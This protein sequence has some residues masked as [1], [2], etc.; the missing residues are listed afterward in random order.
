M[1][2]IYFGWN[3]DWMMFWVGPTF[4]FCFHYLFHKGKLL[5]RKFVVIGSDCCVL[6]LL[7][8]FFLF[9]CF[10]LKIIHRTTSSMD[11]HW[12]RASTFAAIICFCPQIL[13]V[14]SFLPFSC[15]KVLWIGTQ[16]SAVCCQVLWLLWGRG[17]WGIWLHHQFPPVLWWGLKFLYLLYHLS[18]WLMQNKF[19]IILSPQSD[20]CITSLLH[21]TVLTSF[22]CFDIAMSPGFIFWV[23]QAWSSLSISC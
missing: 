4:S 23:P 13:V 7:S 1:K 9:I 15:M 10:I 20:E 16:W 11:C 22:Q 5:I 17:P 12:N 3:L 18:L 6:F 8:S 21:L 19:Y 14:E 2:L